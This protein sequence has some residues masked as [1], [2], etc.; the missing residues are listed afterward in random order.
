MPTYNQ[1][2]HPSGRVVSVRLE[3]S[4][5]SRLDGLEARTNHS[6][7][8]HL[9]D[10]IEAYLSRFEVSQWENCP[11]S[12]LQK[13]FNQRFRMVVARLLDDYA[14]GTQPGISD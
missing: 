13:E 6:R 9:R 7:A 1:K 12:E 10:A 8:H 5:I 11:D 14:P 4:L 2:P 3:E